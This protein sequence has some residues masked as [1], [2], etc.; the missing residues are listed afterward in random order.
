MDQSKKILEVNQAYKIYRGRPIIRNATL[1]LYAGECVLVTGSNCS[2]KTT[3]LRLLSGMM[4]PTIGTIRRQPKLSL[5]YVPPKY[6]MNI[7]MPAFQY[8]VLLTMVDG[9]S[10]AEAKRLCKNLFVHYG[11]SGMEQIAVNQ[12]SDGTIRTMMLAQAL[13]RPCELLVFDAPFTGIDC[14]T[15]KIFYEDMMERKRQNTTFVFTSL[16]P[17]KEMEECLASFVDRIL[18]LE[19]GEIKGD[20]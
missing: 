4:L 16:A 15:Q 6:F 12:L 11:L 2:G 14:D 20:R 9:F 1:K 10:S 17:E 19:H 18:Y 5:Q 8:L 13:L 7:R 3:L